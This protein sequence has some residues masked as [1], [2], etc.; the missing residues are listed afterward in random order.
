[1]LI[2]ILQPVTGVLVNKYNFIIVPKAHLR[3]Q[4]RT[5][6]TV[7]ALSVC[8]CVCVSKTSCPSGEILGYRR[9]LRHSGYL[10]M[11]LDPTCVTLQRIPRSSWLGIPGFVGNPTS[12][13]S[14]SEP[15]ATGKTWSILRALLL[16]IY[17]PKYACH[18]L[19]VGSLENLSSKLVIWDIFAFKSI[20]NKQI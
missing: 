13:W 19:G 16:G 7:S 5:Y 2:A 3:S 4:W 8:L 11:G 1:M 20:K 6:V 15:W 18:N 12:F 17:R 9:L 10:R 14:G